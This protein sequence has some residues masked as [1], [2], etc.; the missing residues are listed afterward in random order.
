MTTLNNIEVTAN[1]L[2]LCLKYK[3]KNILVAS[4]IAANLFGLLW[5]HKT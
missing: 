5:F 1:L 2:E 3:C 4:S